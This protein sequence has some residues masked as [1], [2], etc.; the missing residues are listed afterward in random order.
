M[1]STIFICVL[2]ICSGH[3]FLLTQEGAQC[4]GEGIN[5][6]TE[7]QEAKPGGHIGDVGHP[8]F[9][10]QSRALPGEFTMKYTIIITYY[11]FAL[12]SC[13]KDALL[14]PYELDQILTVDNVAFELKGDV[15]SVDGSIDL[16][17]FFGKPTRCKVL[18][19]NSSADFGNDQGVKMTIIVYDAEGRP[20]DS[21]SDIQYGI[22]GNGRHTLFEL[23]LEPLPEQINSYEVNTLTN[24]GL[25]ASPLFLHC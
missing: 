20:L 23:S 17:I 16:S 18:V 2:R 21:G 5:D 12:I 14:T 15:V 9:L 25:R 1:A 6:N 11:M 4:A 19:L 13:G 3:F 22:L 7:I 10:R 24:R 8:K